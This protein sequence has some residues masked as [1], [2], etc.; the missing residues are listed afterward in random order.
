MADTKA[1][2]EAGAKEVGMAFEVV[3]AN[4]VGLTFDDV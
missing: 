3:Y 1:S 2:E 4:D